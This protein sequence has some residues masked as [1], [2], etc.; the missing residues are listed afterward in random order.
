MLHLLLEW[1]DR[2]T[3]VLLMFARIG[4]IFFIL[5]VLN[6][7]VLANGLIR[8]AVI[9]AIIIGLW[10]VINTSHPVPEL[11]SIAYVALAFKEVLIGCSIGFTLSLPF[12]IFNALGAYIDVARGSSMGSLLDPTSGQESTEMQNF[13]NF[14]V[15]VMYL[16][17]GGMHIILE[18][19]VQSYAN[20]SLSQGIS[21]NLD[22]VLPFLGQLF[23]RGFVLAAPV[24]LTLLLTESLL[25]LLARFTPQLSAFSVAMTIKSSVAIFVLSLYF[26]HM[27]PDQL[28]QFMIEYSHWEILKAVDQQ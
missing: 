25:G 13:I 24:L 12:W 11:N 23:A 16:Q 9:F 10:P 7:S 1:Q 26:W 20:I 8:N 27:V 17:L 5:P 22:V 28:P 21:V 4:P 14:C 19:L 3:T 18:A 15:C 2:L 6:N